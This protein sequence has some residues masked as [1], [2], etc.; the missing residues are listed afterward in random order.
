VGR[1]WRIDNVNRL[2]SGW[3]YKSPSSYE[4]ASDSRCVHEIPCHCD[5]GLEGARSSMD[6]RRDV[7]MLGGIK[8]VCLDGR[9]GY[10]MS[11]TMFHHVTHHIS[12]YDRE[13]TTVR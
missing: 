3:K 6:S 4:Q 13:K 9:R 11:E 10:D 8:G 5:L 1:G 7:E 2:C 12:V